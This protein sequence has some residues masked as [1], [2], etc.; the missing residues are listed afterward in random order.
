MINS[1]EL[2]RAAR[3]LTPVQRSHRIHSNF[4]FRFFHCGL[5]DHEA[6]RL[7][8]VDIE[9]VYLWDD[10]LENIPYLVRQVWLYA[11]GRL[12]PDYSGFDGWFF[13]SGRLVSPSGASYTERELQ[14]IM[15]DFQQ[16]RQLRPS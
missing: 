14:V 16:K 1:D 12:L 15:F 3:F 10:G 9:Q 6:A 13:K 7:V 4:V 11:T 5:S 2:T 8:D